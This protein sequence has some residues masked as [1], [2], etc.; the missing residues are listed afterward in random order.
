MAKRYLN[1]VGRGD[2]QVFEGIYGPNAGALGMNP[3]YMTTNDSALEIGLSNKYKMYENFIVYLD[4]AYLAT[5]MD[6]SKSVWGHS[7][8]NGKD[9]E[10]RDPWNV[11]LSFVYS[12]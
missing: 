1:S 2:Y 7:K 4:A 10:V 5:W 9:D 6:Q 8:M 3:L 11:N 12:F